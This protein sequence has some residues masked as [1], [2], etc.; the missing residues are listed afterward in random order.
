[1]K[2]S[3]IFWGLLFIVFG[4]LVLINNFTTIFMDW[5]AIWKLWPLV[6][7]LLGI[8]IIVKHKYGKGIVAGLA[9]IILAL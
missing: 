7:V 3:H 5:G 1:M 6:I 8:S 4:L 2:T 9:A